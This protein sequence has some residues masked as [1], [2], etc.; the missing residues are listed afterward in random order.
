MRIFVDVGSHIGQTI[1]EV[2][3]PRWS[4]DEI[5]AI[6]PMPAERYVL[7]QRFHADPR[8][9]IWAFAL[10]DYDGSTVI[11]GTN[12]FLEASVW[13]EKDDVDRA[14]KTTVECRDAS[15]FFSEL[16]PG[17]NLTVNMNCEGAEVPIL[18]ALLFSGEVK[19]ITHLMVDFDIRK[20]PGFEQ[21]ERRLRVALDAAG[22]SY[23]AAL[24][25]R[26][27]HQEQIAAWLTSVGL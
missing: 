26:K 13:P 5:H 1:E 18:D 16:D 11:F 23:T 12:E 19:R 3:K 25:D 4:F 14:V 17:A 9:K 8:V 24:P 27:T 7:H 22:I 15:G 6:E 2:V 10:G 21:A 20:V